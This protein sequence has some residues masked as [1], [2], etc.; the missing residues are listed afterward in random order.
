MGPAGA[1]GL[2]ARGDPGPGT[3]GEPGQGRPL[4]PGFAPLGDPRFGPRG[5]PSR[6]RGAGPDPRPDAR[7]AEPGFGP[8][9]HR[10]PGPRPDPRTG[11]GQAARFGPRPDA[12]FGPRPWPDRPPGARPDPGTGDRSAG[13]LHA[14]PTVAPGRDRATGP[15]RG[16]TD[17]GVA[18]EALAPRRV[19]APPRKFGRPEDEQAEAGRARGHEAERGGRAARSGARA[20]RRRLRLWLWTAVAAAVVAA[21]A[22]AVT[23]FLMHGSSPSH[24]LVTPSRLGTFVRRPQIERQMNAR[25]LQQQVVSKSAGQAS[26]VVSAVYENSAG[27]SG[28][29]PPQ[30]F[31]FIGGNLTGVSPSGFIT[32][33]TDQ[34]KGAQTTSAGSLGGR[35]ACVN[36]QGSTA[37]SV[38]L[39]TW[40]DSDTF[41][42]VASPTMSLTQLAA[43]MRAIRPQVERSTR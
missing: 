23:A 38:A 25:Q 6:E 26:R 40:A 29:A 7:P 8:R 5:G 2:P 1:P 16:F 31:L 20:S 9:S 36:T 24:R 11:P 22:V 34:F 15:Q 19:P 18:R 17:D 43:Q 42:V 10:R 33:F 21:A 12:R 37:G 28:S 13:A 35:A 30:I 4:E 41:G 27:V 3:R 39:C 32:S 14:A